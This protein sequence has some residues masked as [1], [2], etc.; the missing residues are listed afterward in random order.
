MK[1]G[2]LT[3]GNELTSGKTADTN[4]SFIARQLNAQGW[5]T[6]VIMSVPDDE[7]AIKKGLNYIMSLSEAV[8]VTGGLG[9]TA[10]DITTSS[11]ATAFGLRIYTDQAALKH[12]RD[13]FE[14][15]HLKWTANNEKQAH[16]PEGAETIKNPVGMAWGYFL[17]RDEKIIAVVPGVPS[18]V[19]RMVPD[20]IIPILRKEFQDAAGYMESRTIKLTGITE[21][22]VDQVLADIDFGSLGVNIGFYPNFPE[23]QIVLTATATTEEEA[24]ERIR[25]AHE[26]VAER[27]KQYIFAY[28][29]DTLEGIVAGALTD[30]NLTLAV[31]ES[32]T[33]GLVTDRLTDVPGSSVFLERS[34][35]AYSNECKADL[36]GVPQDVLKEFGAVS[37]K[38]AVFMAEGVRKLGKCNLGLS[39]TGIAGPAG[40]TVEKPVGTVFIALADG[41]R[42]FCRNYTFRW[43][44]R[45]NK[46]MMSQAALMLLNRYL[47]GK[48][49]ER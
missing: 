27:L 37:E 19:K 11:I 32:C 18:E 35:I 10:D 21:A 45:R 26:H 40:G 8:V 24:K 41:T 5:Q 48:L 22:N 6:S 13:R 42:T 9:P 28:D 7:D 43:D 47:T 49:H 20:Y 30:K 16:A 31:A 25:T 34:V 15:F 33:G 4:S 44:R 1:V 3:I 36:L 12:I 39:T 2:I 17:K 29:R 14:K 38:T 23:I 46:T